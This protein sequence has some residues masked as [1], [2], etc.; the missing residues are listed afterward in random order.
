M[1]MF[2]LGVILGMGLAVLVQQADKAL[3]LRSLRKESEFQDAVNAAAI[4][5][6]EAKYYGWNSA[7]TS[8]TEALA[9][10]GFGPLGW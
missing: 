5:L 3:Q 10:A 1:Y 7:D 9:D 6:A 8:K 2:F 4:Q